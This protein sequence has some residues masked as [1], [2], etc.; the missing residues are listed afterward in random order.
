MNT[1]LEINNLRVQYGLPE[2]YLLNVGTIEERKNALLIVKSLLYIPEKA[3]I[4]LVIVGRESDYSRRIKEFISKNRLEKWV[5]FLHNA[6]FKD[7]PGL[8]QGA[9]VFIYPSLFEG[10]GIPLVEAIESKVPVITTSGSSFVEAAGAHAVYID[11]YNPE[12]LAQAIMKVTE[13]HNLRERMVKES[14]LHI[15]RFQPS[16]IAA[17]LWKL[18]HAMINAEPGH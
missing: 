8:Y 10:F 7:F 9:E 11:P 2:K 4:P 13:N 15:E 12:E 14:S 16:V 17:E 18:Y 6:F 1:A 5:I 3:R